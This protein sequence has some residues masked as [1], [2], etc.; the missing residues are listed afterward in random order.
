MGLL[1]L[2]AL[3]RAPALAAAGAPDLL[4]YVTHSNNSSI[5][6]AVDHMVPFVT[7][8]RPFPFQ[9][10]S[11]TPWSVFA[12]EFRVAANVRGW[13]ASRA[14]YAGVAEAV[15]DAADPS[16]LFWPLVT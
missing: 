10:I 7:G 5:Q 4:S 9:N 11:G 14:V 8:L 12:G 16:T 13:E 2:G 15:G 3:A 6:R 1:Q